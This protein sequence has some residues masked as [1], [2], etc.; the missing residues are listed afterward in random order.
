MDATVA[1]DLAV[2]ACVLGGL[3]LVGFATDANP[4]RASRRWVE[5]LRRSWGRP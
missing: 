5:A 4:S 2:M 3:G 1:Y